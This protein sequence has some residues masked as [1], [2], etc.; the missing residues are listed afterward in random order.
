MP[1][2]ARWVWGGAAVSYFLTR[3]KRTTHDVAFEGKGDCRGG[4][5]DPVSFLSLRYG[6]RGLKRYLSSRQWDDVVGADAEFKV[7]FKLLLVP[8]AVLF[9][10]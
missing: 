7:G 5:V 6:L 1:V 3:E 8:F 10:F 9:R 4:T 2:E